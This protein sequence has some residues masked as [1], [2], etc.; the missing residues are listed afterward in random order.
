MKHLHYS[1]YFRVNPDT[2]K[3]PR[4][5]PYL[6]YEDNWVILDTLQNNLLKGSNKINYDLCREA[7]DRMNASYNAA[8]ER[9]RK[10]SFNDTYF[11]GR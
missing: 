5:E 10:Q 4:Y 8:M 1:T 3:Y 7:C 11:V 6:M 9:Q 2:S